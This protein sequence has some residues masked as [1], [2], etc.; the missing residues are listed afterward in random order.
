MPANLTGTKRSKRACNSCRERKRKCDGEVPCMYCIKNGHECTYEQRRRRRIGRGHVRRPALE[1][2]TTGTRVEENI[3]STTAS[4]LQ[5]IEDNSPAVFL[6]NLGLKIDPAASPVFNY[7]AWNLGFPRENTYLTRSL[8]LTEILSRD[9]MY[10][11][12]AIYFAEVAPVYDFLDREYVRSAV[13]KRWSVPN[14]YGPVDGLICGIAALGCLF[15][16]RAGDQQEQLL[17]IARIILER[18]LQTVTPHIDHVLGWLLRAIYLR[19]AGSQ[20]ATWMA[21]CNLMHMIEATK[22][23]FESSIDSN[24]TQLSDY[25]QP[26]QRRR[27]YSVAQLFNTWVSLDCSR[28][29]VELRG[30]STLMPETSWTKEQQELCRLTELLKPNVPRTFDELEMELSH[31]CYL[32]PAHPMQR[33][34]QCNI[35]LCIYRRVRALGRSLSDRSLSL[36]LELSTKGL[37]S[38]RELIEIMSPW[39]HI[40]NIPFQMVCIFLAID[41]RQSLLHLTDALETLKTVA[42]KYATGAVKESY[43]IASMLVNLQRQR[44]TRELSLLDN[45][46]EGHGINPAIVQDASMESHYSLDENN[47]TLPGN[48]AGDFGITNDSLLDYFVLSDPFHLPQA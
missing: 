6:K 46:L 17:Q 34:I 5:L 11:L 25:L 13:S 42:E 48:I 33:L 26:E 23:H 29:Q 10:E 27:I 30:A 19:M 44:K 15:G 8:Q 3:E 40:V 20:Q 36:I 28:S 21:T 43:G 41:N 31:L 35:A 14:S 39:C 2:N 16:K 37:D 7:Y 24:P 47:F 12:T 38:V 9:Q 4:E 18:S 1:M 22:L 45:V 32:N